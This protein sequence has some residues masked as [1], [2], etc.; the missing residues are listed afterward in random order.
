MTF[1]QAVADT[2]EV[3]EY[4]RER[5]KTDRIVIAGNSWGTLPAV[6]AVQRHPEWFHAFVGAGQMVDAHET[7]TLFYADTLAYAV[8]HGDAAL[9]ARLRELGPP[10]YD[11]FLDYAPGVFAP[12]GEV[13]WND[14]PRVPGST[15]VS[16]MPGTL[17]VEEYGLLDKV[18]TAGAALDV[19]EV[20]Y[21]DLADVDL[22]RSATRLEV[23]IVLVQGRHEARG[24]AELVEEW[25]G[26]LE[27][28]DK[29]LVVFERSGHRPMFEEPDR[30]FEVMTEEVLTRI[31]DAA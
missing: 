31:P 12:G 24:R 9:E 27:A 1:E 19:M 13:L 30:F 14:Y 26:L 18:R 4:L 28:P 23:P 2:L 10:P 8:T 15:G 29:Q 17:L 6:T 21:P 11:R 5:F 25:F 16:E 20:L 22:R 7:D 3:T